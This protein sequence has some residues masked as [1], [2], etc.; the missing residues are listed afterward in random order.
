MNDLG[1]QRGPRETVSLFMVVG[2]AI[3]T[4]RSLPDGSFFPV[5]VG[6]VVVAG[7]VSALLV[8]RLLRARRDRGA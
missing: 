7:L 8:R 2:M 1:P 5:G 4:V 6:V 3:Y